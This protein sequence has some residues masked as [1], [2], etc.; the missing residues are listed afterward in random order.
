MLH[1][2]IKAVSLE[3]LVYSLAI[4]YSLL[5]LREHNFKH[6]GSE[7]VDTVVRSERKRFWGGGVLGLSFLLGGLVIALFVFKQL[8]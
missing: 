3:C 4:M 1:P 6:L 8:E 7:Q 5:C 2:S